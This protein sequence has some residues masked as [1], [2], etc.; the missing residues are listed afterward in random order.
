MV[1]T[2]WDRVTQKCVSKL[3][4][5]G[6]DNC[7]APDRWQAIT[8]TNAGILLIGPSGTGFSEILIE[9]HTFSFKKIH[10]EMVANLSQPQCV[11]PSY[12]YIMGIPLLIRQY[13]YIE[14]RC[15]CL[16]WN[17]LDKLG[18]TYG[19]WCPGHLCR[20][21]ISYYGIGCEWLVASFFFKGNLGPSQYKDEVWP[22]VW[23]IHQL[24]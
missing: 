7:L 21:D 8:W 1:L 14:I 18:Y 23:G 12:L 5:I 13:L 16:H 11:K 2:H 19:S 9:I 17:I 24:M 20:Q 4:I 6:S 10:L 15:C 3:T 22:F